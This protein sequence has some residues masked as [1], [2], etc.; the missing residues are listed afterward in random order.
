VIIKAESEKTMSVNER[1]RDGYERLTNN[2]E[3]FLNQQRTVQKRLSN[4][5]QTAQDRYRTT[6]ERLSNSYQMAVNRVRNGYERLSNQSIP[7]DKER[8]LKD[9]RK[10]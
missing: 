10:K 7:E 5:Y 9:D 2:F 4:S 3:R 8:L 1:R 6:Q